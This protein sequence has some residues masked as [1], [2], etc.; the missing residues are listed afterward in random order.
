MMR[1]DAGFSL[2]ELMTVIGILAILFAIAIPGLI[3]WRNNAQ[4]GRAARDVYGNFQKAK[5]E[6]ARNNVTVAITFAGNVGTVYVDSNGDFNPA[7]EE[8]IG[9]FNLANYAGVN[10]DTS[11]GGATASPLP[12][13]TT[14]LPLRPMDFRWTIQVLWHRERCF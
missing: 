14:P 9:T 13:R 2:M 11:Q 6:A 7:G 3:G 5:I 4:L 12:I 10:L 1:K 8:V